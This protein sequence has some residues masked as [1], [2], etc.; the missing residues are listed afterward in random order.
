M[1]V[2]TVINE[3]KKTEQLHQVNQPLLSQINGEPVNVEICR[4]D[5]S[6]TVTVCNVQ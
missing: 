4:V 3:I 5:A 1:H 2:T 6:D